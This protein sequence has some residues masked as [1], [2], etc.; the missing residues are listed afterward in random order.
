MIYG[1]KLKRNL[2]FKAVKEINL[3]IK[4]VHQIKI[5]FTKKSIQKKI[6]LHHLKKTSIYNNLKIK[7]KMNVNMKINLKNNAIK[8]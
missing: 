7:F 6:S 5:L 2:P 8:K 1:N 4:L 3:Q